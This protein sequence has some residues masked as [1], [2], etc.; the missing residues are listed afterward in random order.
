[1]RILLVNDEPGV[2]SYVKASLE[3][4]LPGCKV[5]EADE[6]DKALKAYRSV[7]KSGYDLVLTDIAHPGMDGLALIDAIRKKNPQQKI[8]VLSG[9]YWVKQKLAES[10]VPFL[11]MPFRVEQLADFVSG[12]LELGKAE[13]VP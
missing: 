3:H 9:A 13:R 7:R 11:Q 5:T 4:I 1:M 12:I 8:G 10:R 2:C 6:G